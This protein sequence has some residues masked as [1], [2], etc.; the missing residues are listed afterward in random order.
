MFACNNCNDSTYLSIKISAGKYLE[1]SYRGWDTKKFKLA[2]TG[3]RYREPKKVITFN[4]KK[5]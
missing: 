5:L 2:Y 1:M 4:N 3:H